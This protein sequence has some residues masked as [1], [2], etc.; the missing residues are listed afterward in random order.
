MSLRTITTTALL[1]SFLCAQTTYAAEPVLIAMGNIS[2]LYEDFATQTA[3][4]DNDF[5]ATL[6]PPIGTGDNPNQFFVF[7]FSDVDLP[8][9]EP[10]RFRD[11]RDDDHDGDHGHDGDRDH[12]R[13]R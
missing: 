2:G 8:F 4:N 9:Y 10:Q 12:D 6:A 7:A 13:R 3:G 11:A 1:T 5:L